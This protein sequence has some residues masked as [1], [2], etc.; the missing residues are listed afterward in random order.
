MS[1]ISTLTI[2][3]TLAVA[4]SSSMPDYSER[5]PLARPGANELRA[6]MPVWQGGISA[7]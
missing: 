1:G 7:R 4:G 2:S 6:E 3:R 5:Q